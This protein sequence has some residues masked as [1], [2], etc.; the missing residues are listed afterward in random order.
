M[1][2]AIPPAM[3]I[4]VVLSIG[5]NQSVMGSPLDLSQFKWGNRLLLL[6]APHRDHPFFF[7]LHQKIMNRKVEAED[8]DLVVFEILESGS[9]TVNSN[10]LDPQTALTLRAKYNIQQGEF[11]IILIGK[12]GGVKL[13]RREQTEIEDIFGLIDSM[14]MRQQEIRNK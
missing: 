14:P 3:I 6:F 2:K 5:S 13:N 4:A 12:D 8:R 1:G 10:D 9:S 7:N 11:A